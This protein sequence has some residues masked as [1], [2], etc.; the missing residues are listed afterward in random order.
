MNTRERF[1]AVFEDRDPTVRTLKWE[2]GYWGQTVNYWYREGLP[3]KHPAV[4]PDKMENPTSS[5]LVTA[6]NIDNKYVNPGEYPEGYLITAGGLYWPS[7]GYA[8]DY[9]VRDYFGMDETQ[10][11]IDLNLL[12]CP[13]YEVKIFENTEDSL[14]YQD[15]DGVTKYFLKKP[16][17]L[18]SA[19]KY[20]LTDWESWKKIKEERVRLDNI[21]DRLPKDWDEKV[22]EYKNRDYPLGIGGTPFGFFG[23]LA[24]VIGYE[25]LFTAYYDEPELIHDI[26]DTFTNMWI[27][28]AAEVMKDVEIDFVQIW[29]DIS[30]GK[31]SM[32]SNV[33]IREFMLPYYKRFIGFLKENGVRVFM[34][35]TDGYC[36]DIIP[37]FIEGGVTAM[38]PFEVHAGMDIVKVREAFPNLV[39]CGGI[40]KMAIGEGKAKIDEILMPVETLLKK[41]GFVPYGDHLIP[42]GISFENFSYYRMK[43]NNLIDRYGNI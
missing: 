29:E 8:L 15:M 7:M 41:G 36:M 43:L 21:R 5:L 10:Y 22:K 14:L 13:A 19:M 4:I 2:F 24:S 16:A 33:H 30:F 40:D 3:R 28:L 6:W 11:L 31:G 38:F 39:I 32:V 34:V 18:P 1:K 23:T 37:L 20:Q 9:D 42:P 27:A 17:V 35:D 12:F 26:M 25:E